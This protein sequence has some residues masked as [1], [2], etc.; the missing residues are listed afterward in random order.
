MRVDLVLRGTVRTGDPWAPLARGVAV[1]DGVVV[2]VDE[3]ALELVG[4]ARE[5]VDLQGGCALPGFGDGHVH[6]L[7]GGVELAGPDVRDATSVAEVVEAVR[8]Y[9]ATHSDDE[10]IQGGPYDPTLAPGGLFDARWLDDALPD[11]PVV[12]QSSDH[13]CAW[14]NSVALRR[15]GVDATTPDPPSGTV[16]RRPDGTPLGTLVEWTAMDLVLRHA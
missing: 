9:A 13:H 8:R 12:L 10:W 16:A 6:P 15:A 5:V 11:R 2:A 7:W 1:N 3:D 4:G 14:V